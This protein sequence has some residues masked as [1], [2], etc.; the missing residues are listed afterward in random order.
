MHEF[1]I[2]TCSTILDERS[3]ED[4]EGLTK[5]SDY[6]EK[7]ISGVYDLPKSLNDAWSIRE[8]VVC[9]DFLVMCSSLGKTFFH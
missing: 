6:A 7:C 5:E 2:L 9:W 1:C 3:T 4:A 8:G